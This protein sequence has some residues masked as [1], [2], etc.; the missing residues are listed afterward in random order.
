MIDVE[1]DG[2]SAEGVPAMSDPQKSVCLCLVQHGEAVPESVDPNRP[3]SGSG[4]AIVEQVAAWAA[5]HGVKVDQIRHSG[6]LRAEQTAAIF[7]DKLR[8]REGVFVQPGVAPN[9]DVRP[10]A[11]AMAGQ[12]G[13]L[14]LVG[15]LPFL[16]RLVGF[17]LVG[18]CERPLVQFRNGGLVGLVRDGANWTITCVIPPALI[19]GA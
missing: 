6:K 4:R 16:S 11:A 13:S 5:R 8:P 10:L 19:S 17:L 9:D 12:S 7:A 14:M 18:D 3:L 15:H 1:N 2:N